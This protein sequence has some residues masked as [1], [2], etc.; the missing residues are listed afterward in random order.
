MDFLFISLR[1]PSLVERSRGDSSSTFEEE[2]SKRARFS[3][4]VEQDVFTHLFP[5]PSILLSR[6]PN[7]P[8]KFVVDVDNEDLAF[9]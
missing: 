3:K 5:L 9:V 2:S 7:T 4:G 1:H 6:V 8:K